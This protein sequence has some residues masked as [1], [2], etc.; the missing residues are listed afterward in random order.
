MTERGP[1][2]EFVAPLL[3]LSSLCRNKGFL[4]ILQQNFPVHQQGE[5]VKRIATAVLALVSVVSLVN[6]AHAG[7][8]RY[9]ARTY[10]GTTFVSANVKPTYSTTTF[11]ANSVAPR[12]VQP[13]N[14]TTAF[15]FN[16]STTIS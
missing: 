16:K 9:V 13:L 2:G 1:T 10:T 3:Q 6:A 4:G 12:S 14:T 8:K 5:K 15:G 11:G 7:S